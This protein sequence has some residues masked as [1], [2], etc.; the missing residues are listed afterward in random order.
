MEPRA[1]RARSGKAHWG[2]LLLLTCAGVVYGQEAKP[3]RTHFFYFENDALVGTDRHYTNGV[4][5]AAMRLGVERSPWWAR[6]LARRFELCDAGAEKESCFK[7]N[8]GLAI[9]HTIYTPDDIGDPE[10]IVDDRPY[11]GW[12]HYSSIFELRSE[13]SLHHLEAD[14]GIVGPLA[15]GEEVQTTVHALIDSAKPMGW[16]HQIDNELGLLLL[17]QWQRRLPKLEIWNREETVRYFDLT[18]DFTGTV[19]NVFTYV[20]AGLTLRL[21]Y[22][23]SEAFPG[24]IEPVAVEAKGERKWEVYVF[25][26][27]EGRAVARNIFLDGNTFKDS[28]SVDKETFVYDWEVGLVIRRGRVAFSYRQITRSPEFT[29]QEGSQTYG[30]LSF[31]VYPKKRHPDP[32]EGQ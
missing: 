32:E 25:A 16:D 14:I 23:L 28:H 6:R 29:L 26:S 20:G 15:F 18:P 9:T 12:L 7:I 13:R 17:Y 19:G 4:R 24:R 1:K 2:L 22:N 3:P 10:L 11:G 5:Y 31:T 27:T 21:G 30:S 8:K